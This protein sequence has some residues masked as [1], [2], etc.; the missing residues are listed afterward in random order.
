MIE[1]FLIEAK[2]QTYANENAPKIES[3]R[4]NSKDYEYRKNNMIYHD[5]YFGG[6]NFIGEEV[7]YVDDK[8]C[9]GMNYYGITLN[10]SFGEEAMDKVLRPSL[11]KVGE[12]NDVIPVR[13]PKE[14]INGDFKYTF[15]SDG[16]INC[17]S[18][19]ESVYKNDI[20]IYE[21]KCIG[22]LIK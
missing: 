20:K 12:D 4:L 18:G 5:T 15:E 7:V 3:T 10:E 2:R 16:D 8:P 19:K 9:W 1:Q 11:M 6:T 17:F 22:G 13:G 14:F 21:L